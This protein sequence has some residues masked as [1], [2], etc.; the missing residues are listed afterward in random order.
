PWNRTALPT[1]EEA[2][3]PRTATETPDLVRWLTMTEQDYRTLCG[4]A[5]LTRAK[6]SGLRR[7]AALVAGN[8]GDRRYLP[9]LREAAEEEDPTVRDAALWA[10]EKIEQMHPERAASS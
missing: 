4:G 9:A 10:I 1:R 8:S 3:L 7:N 2:F 5:A 6:R